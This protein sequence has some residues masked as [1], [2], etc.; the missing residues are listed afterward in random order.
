M[1]GAELL[2]LFV[3]GVFLTETTVFLGFHSVWMKLLLFCHVVVTL[4][5]LRTC[6]CDSYAH[7]FPP[8]FYTFFFGDFAKVTNF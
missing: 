8:R 7:N 1:P 2:R 6:Q 4:F 3:I 5:A